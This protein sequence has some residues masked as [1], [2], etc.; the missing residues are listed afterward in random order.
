ME[1]F[2]AWLRTLDY[3]LY[4]MI[5]VVGG[6][7]AYLGYQLFRD[8]GDTEGSLV[9]IYAA[10]TV[11]MLAGA[12][13]VAVSLYALVKGYYKEKSPSDDDNDDENR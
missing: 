3:T 12:V 2:I 10:G 8:A 5:V 1:K 7:I 4:V 13:L 6:Y 11:F 9:P